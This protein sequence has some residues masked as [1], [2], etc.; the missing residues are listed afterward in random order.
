[1]NFNESDSVSIIAGKLHGRM[2]KFISERFE[3][4]CDR[5]GINSDYYEVSVSVTIRKQDCNFL[6]YLTE[7]T[8]EDKPELR[9]QNL[10]GSKE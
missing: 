3:R 1:M 6:N 10:S 5:E 9:V 2:K 8:I 7:L 4:M